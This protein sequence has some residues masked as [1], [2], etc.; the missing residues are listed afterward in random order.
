[1]IRFIVNVGGTMDIVKGQSLWNEIR[2]ELKNTLVESTFEE[3]FND[4]T[5]VCKVE[6]G[7]I[8]VVTP[9]SYYK[10]KINRKSKS[11]FHKK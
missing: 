9:S 6:N 3:T 8:Y 5:R 10:H 11:A 7:Y 2:E 1:M 4:V